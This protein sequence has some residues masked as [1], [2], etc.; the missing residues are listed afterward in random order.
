MTFLLIPLKFFI[1]GYPPLQRAGTLLV[2]YDPLIDEVMP[3]V[4]DILVHGLWTL[5]Y[6]LLTLDHRS[7]VL[8][9]MNVMQWVMGYGSKLHGLWVMDLVLGHR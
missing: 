2:G 1:S 8:P 3:D 5:G 6:G 4:N 7:W 9:I